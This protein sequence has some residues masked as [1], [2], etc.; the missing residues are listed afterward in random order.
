MATPI[1][2]RRV[3]G[4]L[5]FQAGNVFSPT[6]V[7]AASAWAGANAHRVDMTQPLEQQTQPPLRRCNDCQLDLGRDV[8]RALGMC[9]R[10]GKPRAGVE[11]HCPAFV[12]KGG[13]R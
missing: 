13:V 4:R 7:Q 3:R 9:P 8:L 11:S 5:Y 10:W 1:I 6:L 12:A 2:P